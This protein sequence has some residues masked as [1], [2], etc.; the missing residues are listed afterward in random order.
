MMKN[1][2]NCDTSEITGKLSKITVKE[3]EKVEV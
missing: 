1:I 3:G 2:L